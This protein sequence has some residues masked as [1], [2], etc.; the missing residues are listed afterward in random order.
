VIIGNQKMTI[1]EKALHFLSD[2]YCGTC[3]YYTDMTDITDIEMDEYRCG[4]TEGKYPKDL[5]PNGVCNYWEKRTTTYA[6]WGS[7]G[8]IGVSDRGFDDV[9]RK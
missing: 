8:Q 7:G 6:K 1:D 3:A 2:H 5:D 4:R 9:A